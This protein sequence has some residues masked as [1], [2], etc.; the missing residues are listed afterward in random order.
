ML[1]E[2]HSSELGMLAGAVQIGSGYT[3]RR[4]TAKT[5]ST[6]LSERIQ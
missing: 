1:A 4:E 5:L 6:E 2:S 3:E